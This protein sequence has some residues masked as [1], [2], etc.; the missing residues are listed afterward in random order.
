[1]NEGEKFKIRLLIP[2]EE[3]LDK[4]G[5][6]NLEASTSDYI[7]NNLKKDKKTIMQHVKDTAKETITEIEK[8]QNKREAFEC[9]ILPDDIIPSF[10][11]EFIDVT[12]DGEKTSGL[13]P[14]ANITHIG[15]SETSPTDDPTDVVPITFTINQPNASDNAQDMFTLYKNTF[16]L[17]WDKSQDR[18]CK[19]SVWQ[20][21]DSP[22]NAPPPEQST[23]SIQNT[24]KKSKFTN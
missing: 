14:K 20:K 21:K 5:T 6:R 10:I 7:L 24:P 16:T 2:S 19:K 1:M 17:L 3:G 4:I 9:R 23:G 15:Y 8:K 11:G 12:W 22:Q 13:K 18:P